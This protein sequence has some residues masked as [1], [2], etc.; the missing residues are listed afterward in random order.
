M[1]VNRPLIMLLLV[2]TAISVAASACRGTTLS[3]TEIYELANRALSASHSYEIHSTKFELI[4]SDVFTQ[5]E[6][7]VQFEQPAHQ[8]LI[9]QHSGQPTSIQIG[10]QIFTRSRST[11]GFWNHSPYYGFYGA[12]VPLGVKHL[13]E[14]FD[15]SPQVNIVD[16]HAIITGTGKRPHNTYLS[17]NHTGFAIVIDLSDYSAKHVV[18]F[19]RTMFEVDD[20]EIRAL[21]ESNWSHEQLLNVL[22]YLPVTTE[23]GSVHI[24]SFDRYN[25]RFGIEPVDTSQIITELK[26]HGPQGIVSDLE[27]TI[28]FEF[29]GPP[30]SY[31]ISIIPFIELEKQTSWFSYHGVDLRVFEYKPVTPLDRGKNYTVTLGWIE[32][33]GSENS[34][35]WEIQTVQ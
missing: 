8:Q 32:F 1:T 20:S 30:E 31:S 5:T 12:P 26:R 34:I 10:P 21:K 27:P 9:D 35:S 2:I 22:A 24:S 23:L 14:D 29:T 15:L 3:A 17:E 4:G 28:H 18:S 11:P 33:E 7:I 25:E 16:G 19:D 13:P 6:T